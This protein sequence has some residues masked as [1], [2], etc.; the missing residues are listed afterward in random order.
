MRNISEIA[1]ELAYRTETQRKKWFDACLQLITHMNKGRSKIENPTL[2]G[3]T[4]YIIKSFQ[5]VHILSFIHMQRYSEDIGEFT[6]ILCDQVCSSYY[7]YCAPYIDR[8]TKLKQEHRGEK[9][10]EQF[11]IF[12]ADIALS[13]VGSP[14]GMMLAPAVDATVFDFYTRN[15]ILAAHA[16]E[17]NET[18]NKLLTGIKKLHG[19]E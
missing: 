15:L 2:N 18:A 4:E 9:F 12:A 3:T 16:F 17:N 6:R 1:S 19:V 11:L 7:E 13:I 8:Y 14:A 5:L 10:E